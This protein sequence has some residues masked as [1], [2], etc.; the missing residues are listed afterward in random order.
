MGEFFFLLLL[1]VCLLGALGYGFWW[2]LFVV[3]GVEM[4]ACGIFRLFFLFN[5]YYG[6]IFVCLVF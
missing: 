4:G 1:V 6:L 3:V 5:G 2:V